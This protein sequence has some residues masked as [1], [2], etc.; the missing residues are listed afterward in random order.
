MTQRYF[1]V[2]Y[3]GSVD[4]IRLELFEDILVSEDTLERKYTMDDFMN[5]L[6][7]ARELMPGSQ[8]KVKHPMA[9]LMQ[10]Q[11]EQ[12]IHPFYDMLVP[13]EYSLWNSSKG[14]SGTMSRLVWNCKANIPIL[15]PQTV[16]VARLRMIFAVV[17]HRLSEAVTIAKKPGAAKCSKRT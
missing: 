2:F 5:S 3:R 4:V 9:M 16:V 15:T 6:L 17:F 12:A 8:S 14:G 7:I 13:F 1:T 10:R 11:R